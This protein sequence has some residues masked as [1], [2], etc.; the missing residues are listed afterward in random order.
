MVSI[1]AI[2]FFILLKLLLDYIKIKP[3]LIRI[4]VVFI[5]IK[6][7]MPNAILIC[8]LIYGPFLPEKNHL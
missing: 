3:I 1:I 2:L 5:I 4:E 6:L 7:I 8:I